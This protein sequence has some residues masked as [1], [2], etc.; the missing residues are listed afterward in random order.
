MAEFNLAELLADV[1]GLDTGLDREQ[2]EYID[3]DK[4][5]ADDRNFYKIEG[6]EGLM[7]SI[8]LLGLQQPVRVRAEGDGYTIVSG[9]RR[10]EAIRRLVAEGQ[11]RFRKVACIVE[12]PAKSPEL[13]ELRL[14][15]ANSD[16][17]VLTSSEIA[18]QAA[19]VKELLY[20]LKEQGVEFP[21]RMRDHVAEACK[22]SRTKLARLEAIEKNLA[23]ELKFEYKEGKLN[24]ACAYA[25]SQLPRPDQLFIH[26]HLKRRKYLY[27]GSI[28]DMSKYISSARER[29][30]P[31]DL[32]G[33][34]CEH[35]EGLAQKVFCSGYY[36]YSHCAHNGCCSNCPDIGSCANVC[37]HMK[38]AAK[39]KKAEDREAKQKA[40]AEKAASE[41][42]KIEQIRAIWKRFGEARTAA[43][44]SPEEFKKTVGSYCGVNEFEAHERLE[45]KVSAQTYLPYAGLF[46]DSVIALSAA[47]GLFGCSID[48]LLCLS[49]ERDRV[50]GLNTGAQ[51]QTDGKVE[52]GLYM[53]K[54]ECEGSVI[55][56]QLRHRDSR[57]YMCGGKE[58][59]ESCKVAAW[60]PLPE[61]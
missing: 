25:L 48:Y 24:E 9:H 58:I 36:R 59:D 56:S 30:C 18:E 16:T 3:V 26:E 61:D 53:C 55:K 43:G 4:L 35:V 44:V 12:S 20:K 57:W 1:S 40:A 39:A 34:K 7:S 41:L 15:Y 60:W 13:Q 37:P 49:D 52:D 8:E 38:D 5:R 31:E 14:I 23:F 33:G 22:I 51:W 27:E 10:T 46:L 47:A 42:P 50:S 6:I 45:A 28:K 19:K 17:R 32:R 21:G 54:V 2:L 11:E 29:N